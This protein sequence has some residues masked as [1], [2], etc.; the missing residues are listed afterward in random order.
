M[1][2]KPF[3][4]TR[5]L[6]VF[7]GVVTPIFIGR[8]ASLSSLE[9][10]L[11][12]FDNKL[13]L[14]TQKDPNVEEPKLPEDVYETGV[15][16]HVIQTVKM[17]NG[18]VKVLVEAKHRV[19]IGEFEEKKGVQYAD[20]E[21]IFPKPIEESKSE[22]LKRRVIDE[23]SN[24]AKIT[25]KILPD[26]IYNIKEVRNIDKAFDLICTNL[27]IATNVKQ[28]LLEILDVEERAYKIL[29]IL[30]KEIEIFTLE[31]EIENKVKEQMAEVQ[32][33]YYLREK[34][35][36]MREEMGEDSDSDEELE[37]LDQRV[38]DSK[39]PKEL[40]EKMVKELSRLKKMPDFSA[41][42]SVIRSYVET[43][44][45][46]P[47]DK[48]TKDEIDIQKAEKILD[49]DHYGLEEVKARILEFLA[50]KKLNNT[51]KGSIICLVG[52]PGVGKTSLANSVARSMNRKFTRI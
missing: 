19:L 13:I 52:P 31:R 21:E 40:K 29:S 44:L 50:V 9:E 23:F 12:S 51:L 24:Y 28:E 45:E 16:V 15:L 48:S 3:I 20:Y 10:A 33:N 32:K 8:Q 1:L 46:L 2:K 41:E 49:E 37:E 47:W 27:M 6:V 39:I 26:V 38:Q 22:A 34:I 11:S 5:E 42:A 18:N 7:P 36:A 30:E 25:Q 14:S 35:K 17:P 43:V 4:A